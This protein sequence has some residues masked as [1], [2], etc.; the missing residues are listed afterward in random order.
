M[1]IAIYDSSLLTQRR[2]DRVIAQQ[3][4][5]SNKSGSPII[6]PQAGYGSYQLGEAKNGA[7]T[8]FRKGEG[9][10]SIN[11][12]CNCVGQNS[13]SI[14]VYLY[15]WI[16]TGLVNGLF[17]WA[18]TNMSRDGDY[19]YVMA[20]NS[21]SVLSNSY[22]LYINNTNWINGYNVLEPY[23]YGSNTILYSANLN[24][25][26]PDNVIQQSINNGISFNTIPNTT[27]NGAQIATFVASL[28]GQYVYLSDNEAG[29]AAYIYRFNNNDGSF[30]RL[31]LA[32]EY[33]WQQFSCSE[34]GLYVYA[35]TG[36]DAHISTDYGD[37]WA[38][39]PGNGDR[40]ITCS[41]N[42]S[43]IYIGG[44]SVIRKS[45]NNGSNFTDISVIYS[46]IS[47]SCSQD[48]SIVYFVDSTIIY[49]STNGGTDW[50]IVGPP[51]PS[52]SSWTSIKVSENGSVISACSSIGSVYISRDYGANWI[53]QDIYGTKPWLAIAISD[54]NTIVALPYGEYPFT[55][56]GVWTQQLTAPTLNWYS[57]AYASGTIF[58]AGTKNEKIYK[59][60]DNGL[61]WTQIITID[62]QWEYIASSSDA[63]VIGAIFSDVYL[64]FDGGTTWL[65][66]SFVDACED[67]QISLDG[68][69]IYVL[70]GV[71]IFVFQSGSFVP[72]NVP[73]SISKFTIS[74]SGS[75]IIG[76][77]I[78]DGNYQI[79]K[80]IN[81]GLTWNIIS[82]INFDISK[83]VSSSDCSILA[84]IDSQFPYSIYISK[85]GG[86]IWTQQE[87]LS[88]FEDIS[89]T[90]S[91]DKIAA[92]QN[93]GTV[94]IGNI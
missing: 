74:S 43:I 42:G 70:S 57:I 45:I 77:T 35:I 5:N 50:S 28:N 90:S 76:Y 84:V 86:Y 4:F 16:D 62:G 46:P 53:L 29:V 82:T 22:K 58:I 37:S 19:I 89:I 93:G 17:Q 83:I 55:Y 21:D 79:V 30:I 68:T 9:C 91:G 92:C 65:P 61:Y 88:G 39:S 36:I 27:G 51:A 78:N 40:C 23:I 32:G 3:I 60:V 13:I 67:I 26:S 73:Y 41:Y 33:N 48:G 75:T 63:Q 11:V 44:S 56:N 7:I 20:L 14:P 34:D 1:P 59:T 38:I 49:K 15:N 54:T 31:D 52:I 10:T 2:R 72:L 85:D 66:Y 94:W 69:K 71:D 24:T 6:I 80:S 87:G 64:T 81:S 25:A 18:F 8:Y 12:S 47:I